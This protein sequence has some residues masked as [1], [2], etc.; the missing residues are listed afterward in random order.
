LCG[1]ENLYYFSN[2]FKKSTGFS[3]SAFRKRINL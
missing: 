2:A 3:P 1:F